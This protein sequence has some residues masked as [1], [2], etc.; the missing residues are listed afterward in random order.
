MSF[1]NN[2][3]VVTD[4]LILSL[5]AIDN[6]SFPSKDLPVK[7]SNLVAWFDATDDATFSY[8]S[9]SNVARWDDKSGNEHHLYQ[10][11][12][13]SSPVRSGSF[14]SQPIVVFDGTDDFL[15]T[16]S[17]I[18]LTNS[19]TIFVVAR[20]YTS[21]SDA[22]VISINDSLASGITI[23][24]GSL[25]YFYYGGG[26]QAVSIS[27]TTSETNIL[28]KVWDGET[29]GDRV[30][31]K[32]GSKSTVNGVMS[33]T[34][35]SGPLRVGLQTSYLNG[36]IGEILIY[37]KNL[38]DEDIN[39]VHTYLQNKW[40]IP[41]PGVT[42]DGTTWYNQLISTENA[43]LRDGPVFNSSYFSFDGSNDRVTMNPGVDLYSW[44]PSG[45]VNNYLTIET[46]VRT[47]ETSGWIFSKPWNGSGGYNYRLKPAEYFVGTDTGTTVGFTSIADGNWKHVVMLIDPVNVTVYVNGLEHSSPTAHGL[48]SNDHA[49]GNTQFAIALMTLYPYT[50][51]PWAGDTTF[52]IAGD[53]A[54][55]KMY[56]RTLSESEVVQNYRSHKTRFGL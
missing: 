50:S 36:L 49:N 18:D 41:S 24:N 44:K 43:V 51:N 52:S 17:S 37:D 15:R 13:A 54:S 9:G 34:N 20:S 7:G 25:A 40:S 26:G 42:S 11:V 35:A 46:W 1:H 30:A 6:K 8:G 38:S 31:Y 39:K 10:D 23:H 3:R 32:N 16:S 29:S 45:G 5:D 14:N 22:G 28:T 55:F 48:S 56:N 21:V 19:S 53:M 2:P 12:V 4:N 47:S 27:V 33:D